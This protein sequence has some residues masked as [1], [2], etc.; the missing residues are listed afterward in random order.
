MVMET[1]QQEASP[2]RKGSKQ[3]LEDNMA[4]IRKEDGLKVNYLSQCS[5]KRLQEIRLPMEPMEEECQIVKYH[6][7]IEEQMQVK[8]LELLVVVTQ[9]DK[10]ISRLH[11]QKL[12]R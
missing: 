6:K 7:V 5:S 3:I 4:E 12:Q 1:R 9:E 11:S 8:H 2:Q 10:T